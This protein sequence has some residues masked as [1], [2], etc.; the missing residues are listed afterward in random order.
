M[1]LAILLDKVATARFNR[2][3]TGDELVLPDALEIG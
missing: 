3:H 2:E 1:D